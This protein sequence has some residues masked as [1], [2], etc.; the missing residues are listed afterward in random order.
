M[1]PWHPDRDLLQ[2]YA[3]GNTDLPLAGSVETH[4]VACATCRRLADSVVSAERLARIWQGIEAGINAPRP[5]TPQR[6]LVHLRLVSFALARAVT[7]FPRP[8]LRILVAMGGAMLVIIAI[9]VMGP[10]ARVGSYTASDSSPDPVKTAVIASPGGHTWT[11]RPQVNSGPPHN[12]PVTA[13]DLPT[14]ARS[15]VIRRQ[16][17]PSDATTSVYLK[18]CLLAAIDRQTAPLAATIVLY[19]HDQAGSVPAAVVVFSSL[20]GPSRLDV[21]AVAKDCAGEKG[22]LLAFQQDITRASDDQQRRTNQNAQALT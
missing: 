6:I 18:P 11:E 20:K 16:D 12:V 7:K 3:A 21:Y 19:R 13:A 17:S 10:Y 22:Q 9:W 5:T 4:L 8:S 2:R 15:L 1:N 14:V